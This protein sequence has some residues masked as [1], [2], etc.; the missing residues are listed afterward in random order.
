MKGLCA[1]AAV[2]VFATGFVIGSPALVE[3]RDTPAMAIGDTYSRPGAGPYKYSCPCDDRDQLNWR[4]R[5]LCERVPD[6]L[7]GRIPSWASLAL[8]LTKWSAVWPW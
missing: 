1:A 5:Y 3:A 2:V 6:D 4:P 7:N 8:R